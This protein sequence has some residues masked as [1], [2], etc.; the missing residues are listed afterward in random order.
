MTSYNPIT[1]SKSNI[2]IS[3]SDSDGRYNDLT[4]KTSGISMWFERWFLSS[5]AKDIGVLYLIYAL[6]AGLIGTAFSVLIRLELSGPGVQ[7]IADNQL[8]NSIIT[9]HAIIM[10]FFMVMP[11]LIGGF[12]NFLLPLGLGGPDMGFPRLNNISY[13][14]L[15]PSIVLFLFAGGIENGVGTGWTLYPPLSGIQSHSGPSVDL[16]IFG[17]HLSGIS[18][19]LGAMNFMTTTFNMRSPGIRL[20]K[21]ILFA[22]AVVITAVLLL[23]SLPV[24][25]GGITMVL[26]DRNFNTSFFEV[27]GGGDPILY[28]HLFWFFGHP[29]VY[30]LIIPGFGIISTT[31]SANSNKS[32]FGYLGMV[33]AMC[34]IGILGFVVWS[35][36]MYT[37]GLDVDTRAYFTAA[38]LIIAVPT[39]IKIFSWLATCYGGSLHFIPSL[40]FALG[41]VFMFTIGGLSGV[42][43]ANASLDIAFHDTYYVVAQLGLNNLFP[44]ADYFAFGYMLETMFL[45][46]CL[47]CILYY[48]L[49][50]IDASRNLTFLTIHSQN[51]NKP[52]FLTNT[53]IQSAENCK[54]FSE[55]TRQISDSKGKNL[56]N[57]E[58]F[59]WL[60]GIIDG[61]GN[62]DIRNVN[63]NIVLKT[64]RIK[65]HNRDIRILSYIQNMLH[66]G[67]IRS[68][69]NKPHSIW[70]I[71]KKE[72]MLFLINNING[73]IRLKVA[74]LQKS[75]DYL[76]IAYKQANY[77]IQANDPY[78]AGLVDTD[79]TI[80]YNYS[81]NR[82]ECNL[83][84]ENNEFSS[85]LN[86]DNVIPNYKPAVLLRK[87][88]NSIS[89][90]YQ[91]V[92][93]M[94]FLYEYFMK[95]RLYSDFKFYRISKIKKFIEI[96]EF[97]NEPKESFEYKIYSEFILD[98]IQ[99]K[100]PLWQKVPFV[101]KIR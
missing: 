77:N 12:G 63:S 56:S 44:G 83:E 57:K 65:L 5:N 101:E 81:G 53:N 100:N 78:L 19:L 89:Y 39:G 64:I 18:S 37:V 45:G 80:V 96:R 95:N 41:F 27:A 52:V 21:L 58:F 14:L 82:I 7:Y 16:A 88:H 85:K 26:T 29:E 28:Q 74:G 34:S 87:S 93:G 42:V 72:Q 94:V 59:K 25:A 23:L 40:L 75:C 60:A 62:F 90:K 50:K 36:H 4:M 38:T 51:N 73:L 15:I 67:T 13:L 97:K 61:D 92:K 8:Y 47:L 22:W 32:V 54:G 84:L 49:F 86:L 35:H 1:F 48:Y 71:S 3:E 17:L 24:L 99:Y 98:W 91:N 55:T 20:H 69:K 43:L 76:G 66:I 31:I 70:I 79:G 9:A 6:F 68:D 11:A 33:Y 10:I 2:I 30:I 46:C